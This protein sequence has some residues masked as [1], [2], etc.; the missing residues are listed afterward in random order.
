MWL[1]SQFML[2]NVVRDQKQ[3]TASIRG[4]GSN[5]SLIHTFLKIAN[6]MKRGILGRNCLPL[7]TV[8]HWYDDKLTFSLRSLSRFVCL[9]RVSASSFSIFLIS[10]L[11]KHSCSCSNVCSKRHFSWR[12]YNSIYTYVKLHP[13]LLVFNTNQ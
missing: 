9:A 2:I 8:G 3:L 1:R 11:T 13:I 12:S 6:S 7:L 5:I 4:W 10:L